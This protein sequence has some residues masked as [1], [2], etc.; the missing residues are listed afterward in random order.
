MTSPVLITEAPPDI[1]ATRIGRLARADLTSI[2]L[3]PGTTHTTSGG[4]A[5]DVL[6]ALGKIH[7]ANGK[8]RHGQDNT[9]L[10][11]I[12]LTAHRT[13]T[14]Y[15]AAPQHTPTAYLLD[16]AAMLAAS[17]ATLWLACDH[18]YS[19]ALL[20]ALYST[21]PQSV[22]WPQPTP[23]TSAE[24][25]GEGGTTIRSPWRPETR[26]ALPDTEF[27][28]FYAT[29]RAVLDDRGFAPVDALYQ[30][31]LDR[32]LTWLHQTGPDNITEQGTRDALTGLVG[33]QATLDDVSVALKA[34]QA[35]FFRTGWY[36]TVDQR[37]LRSGLLRFPAPTVDQPTWRLLRAYRDTGRAATVALYLA[38]MTATQIRALTVD[39][40]A[41]WHAD[42][43]EPLADVR[44]P[45]D[46]HPYLRAHLL[47]RTSAA[48]D[49]ADPAFLGA[50]R[51]VLL[52]LREA[53]DDLGLNLGDAN[54][55]ANDQH[56]QRR[57]G[58]RVFRLERLT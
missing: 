23:S 15:V 30:K 37:E 11:P 53:S 29:A 28:T 48:P 16:L 39:D 2:V 8:A 43:S 33:E 26:P 35:A 17:P 5:L 1:P 27:L 36:L 38:G 25:E 18:G 6:S 32:T 4:V 7:E 54:L 57:V 21:A 12:W 31:S 14:V 3:S 45:E 47:A 34:A 40:L 44:V 19:A 42:T 24:G 13:T 41:A 22:P 58:T 9:S 10:V 50:A 55:T 49:P 20:D 51:R 56:G 46:A 52:D